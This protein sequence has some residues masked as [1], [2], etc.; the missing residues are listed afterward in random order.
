MPRVTESLEVWVIQGN[1][2]M[3]QV[4]GA[5]QPK[6]YVENGRVLKLDAALNFRF[7]VPAGG[8]A[9]RCDSSFHVDHQ[10]SPRMYHPPASTHNRSYAWLEA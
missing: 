10:R 9:P 1:N 5:D 4:F 7:F 3:M 2:W 8:G 6:G